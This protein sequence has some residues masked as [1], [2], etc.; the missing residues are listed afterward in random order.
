MT[1]LK[2]L[3][4]E[5][6]PLRREAPPSLDLLHERLQSVLMR[7]PS[8]D[9]PVGAPRRALLLVPVSIVAALGIA[10]VA[11]SRGW[12]PLEA[13]LAAQVRF[14]MRLA[15]ENPAPGL[16]V[17]QDV[18]SGR[19]VYLHP[20]GVVS[21]DDLSSA[22]VIDDGSPQVSVGVEFLASGAER[23]REATAQHRGRPV[24]I[25]IDGVVV[26]APIVRSP[27][28]ESAVITGSFTREAATRIAEGMVP[29]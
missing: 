12:L 1:T 16:H 23:M 22:W 29:R 8:S 28:S 27:I 17:A 7:S 3:L 18:G 24:A 6:D 13:P 10:W 2:Q 25:L 19:L 21:N 4:Q 9:A 5:A 11:S 14:E 26:M 20:E 15:E